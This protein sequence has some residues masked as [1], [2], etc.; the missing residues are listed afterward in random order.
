M[1]CWLYARGFMRLHT[2]SVSSR[3]TH[4]CKACACTVLHCVFLWGSM[5]AT[6]EWLLSYS[7]W[8]LA[9]R[10]RAFMHFCALKRRTSWITTHPHPQGRIPR[11]WRKGMCR[12]HPA[13]RAHCRCRLAPNCSHLGRNHRARS[14]WCVESLNMG[15]RNLGSKEMQILP[16]EWALCKPFLCTLPWPAV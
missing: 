6:A 13:H 16:L 7:L 14:T 8:I 12:A 4:F 2:F 1:E 3:C 15:N 11:H 10:T 5:S 9:V